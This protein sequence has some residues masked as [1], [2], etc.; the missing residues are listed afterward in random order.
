MIN[1]NGNLIEHYKFCNITIENGIIKL[2][3][4]QDEFIVKDFIWTLTEVE[5]QITECICDCEGKV[6]RDIVEKAKIPPMIAY[7]YMC[8]FNEDKIPHLQDFINGYIKYHKVWLQ[9]FIN[10][11][12]Q[13]AIEGRLSRTFPS[14]V[15][16][17]HFYWLLSLQDNE[18]IIENKY[19]LWSGID[20]KIIHSKIYYS[21]WRDLTGFDFLYIYKGIEYYISLFIDTTESNIFNNADKKIIAREK[22]LENRQKYL[23]YLPQSIELA[24]SKA[25]YYG[26]IKLYNEEYLKHLFSLINYAEKNSQIHRFRRIM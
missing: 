22:Y 4:T 13:D 8:I 18:E 12:L 7:F 5:K 14:L 11:G 24:V 21:L 19:S 15:R 6:K 1:E 16:D 10:D 2:W 26:N 23:D 25:K 20:T 9:D 17:F 3:I